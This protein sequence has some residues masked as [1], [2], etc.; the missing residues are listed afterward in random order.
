MR[1][2]SD[3][4]NR[5]KRLWPLP[6]NSKWIVHRDS[7]CLKWCPYPEDDEDP[8]YQYYWTVVITG[9]STHEYNGKM[10]YDRSFSFD[11][12]YYDGPHCALRLYFI[13]IGWSTPWTS[14]KGLI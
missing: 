7:I 14:R 6:S 3:K 4:I 1:W 11:K 8:E 5:W 13:C 9:N 12:M 2:L 10:W